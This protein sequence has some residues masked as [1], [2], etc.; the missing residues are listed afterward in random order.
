MRSNYNATPGM[1]YLAHGDIDRGMQLYRSAADRAEQVEPAMRS[2]MTT[3]QALIVR[4]LGLDKTLPPK[5]IA[6]LSLVPFDLPDDWRDRPDFLR[7]H[8]ICIKNGYDWP[9]SL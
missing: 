6:T 3:Y 8:A 2:L 1:A 7:L 5:M 9:L 4:Q